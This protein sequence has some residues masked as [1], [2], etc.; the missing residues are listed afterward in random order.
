MLSALA[1]GADRIVVVDT[2]TTGVYPS[3]RI[4][5]TACVTLD[6]DGRVVDEFDTLV[7]PQR[8]VGPT[9]I[10]RVTP[11]MLSYP[12]PGATL[13]ATATAVERR[14]TLQCR[15]CGRH[16]SRPVSRGKKPELCQECTDTAKA[17]TAPA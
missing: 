8:D 15:S 12:G 13:Q 7:D 1:A 14:E 3:D 10:H 9:W 5:E 6:L 16:W 4:V 11:S 2:E 17:T